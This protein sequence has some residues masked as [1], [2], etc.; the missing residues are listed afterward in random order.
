ME[1]GWG[2]K[3][4][5]ECNIGILPIIMEQDMGKI[6]MFVGTYFVVEENVTK[7]TSM[8]LKNNGLSPE[9]DN[10]RYNTGKFFKI[11]IFKDHKGT[12][13]YVICNHAMDHVV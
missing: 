9:I 10:L 5:L 3:Q 2:H 6:S 7:C 12:T 4:G 1:S 8:S 11:L 13:C